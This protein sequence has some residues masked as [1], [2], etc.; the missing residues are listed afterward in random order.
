VHTFAGPSGAPGPHPVPALPVNG[1]AA[2]GALVA[3]DA[4]AL[5]ATIAA[6][7]LLGLL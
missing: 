5:A 6:L 2:A 1:T 7:Q 3:S 4:L